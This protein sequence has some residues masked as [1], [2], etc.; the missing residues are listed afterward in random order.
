MLPDAGGR[1]LL[2][3]RL[4]EK[5]Y[6]L[7]HRVYVHG[8]DRRQAEQFDELLWTFKQN[9]FVPHAL[10]G[11]ASAGELSLAPV[12]I[13]WEDAP[14]PGGPP[15]VLINLAESVPKFV[16]DGGYQKVLE[17]VDQEPAARAAARTRFKHYRDL[18]IQP[19]SH[20]L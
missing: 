18:G 5:A 3:C 7:G 6:S 19:D 2:A 20:R 1:L 4:A 14:A 12:L 16:A 10:T 15:D 9:S 13:G 17:V 11:D 8:D